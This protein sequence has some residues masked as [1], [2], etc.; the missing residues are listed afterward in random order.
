[1][2]QYRSQDGQLFRLQRIAQFRYNKKFE[3]NKIH[4]IGIG[5]RPLDRKAGDIVLR[6]DVVLA[7][8]RLLEVFKSYKEYRQVKN[9]IVVHAGVYE[10]IEYISDNYQKKM[11]SLLA[12]GD[13]MFFGIGRLIV[14]RFGRDV[15]EVYP[16]LSSVQAAFS[17]IRE[18][19]NNALLMSLHGGPDPAKRR[20]PE[21]E[22]A[23]LPVLL[24]QYDRIA[25]L[26]DRVNNP[27]EIAK[28]ILKPGGFSR[29]VSALTM[30]VCER[31]GYPD[32]KI[33]QG[34]PEE[35]SHLSFEHPNVVIIITGKGDDTDTA[36]LS[37]IKFGLKETEIRHT[38]GL[39]TKDEVR[40]AAIHKLRLPHRGVFWDIGAG[41]GS[42]SIEAARLCPG[43]RVFA[44]EKNQEQIRRLNENRDGFKTASMEIIQ[45][46]APA[47]LNNLPVPD[48]VFVG[49]SAGKLALIADF[50]AEKMSSGIIV[51]NAAAI[52]TLND[53]VQGL[54]RNNFSVEVSQVSVSRSKM[55]NDR[56]LMTALNPIFIITGERR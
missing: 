33:R 13:P 44:V 39:I 16:D 18:I 2:V 36:A 37:N 56:T 29:R 49:G 15:V 42:V 23:E 38:N 17:R 47:A 27:A 24:Q 40:A 28:E 41:S 6:S 22:L 50:L 7:G 1:M 46:E 10:T 9:R 8:S 12:A 55:I 32:E 51:I 4:V 35:I 21:H 53:A 30:Y 45:G 34:T 52:E 48:R 3:M 54:V 43:L 19:S 31:L 26:T 25:I 20:K 5:F 11:L 14:E